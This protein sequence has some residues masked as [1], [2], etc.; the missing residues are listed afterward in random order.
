MSKVKVNTTNTF[1]EWRGKTNEI[2]SGLGDIAT[3]TQNAVIVYTNNI[4]GINKDIFIGDPATFNVTINNKATPNPIYEITII[5][6]GDHYAVDDTITILGSLVGGVDSVNDIIITVSAITAAESAIDVIT[7]VG[8]PTTDLVAE[9]NQLRTEAGLE[10]LTTTSK[11]FSGAINELDALQ[12]NV[13]L[14]TTAQTVTGAI[15]EHETDIGTVSSLTTTANN[16][17]GATNELDALQGNVNIKGTKAASLPKST[18][19]TITDAVKQIDEFQ[20]NIVLTTTAQTVTGA[21]NELDALQGNVSLTTT[22]Q[23]VT[24]AILEHETDIGSMSFNTSNSSIA[25][26]VTAGDHVNL[27]SDITSALNSLKSRSDFALDTLGGKLGTVSGTNDYDGG[28]ATIIE[29]LNALYE[30]SSLSTLDNTY[31][32]RNGGLDMTG[33]LKIDE[34]GITTTTTTDD[35]NVVTYYPMLFKVGSATANTRIHIAIDG[36]VGIGKTPSL[37]K[38]DVSGS[39]N[40]T[41]HLLDGNNIDSR[42]LRLSGVTNKLSVSNK[43]NFTSDLEYDSE[44]IDSRY[45]RTARSTEQEVST[46][47]KFTGVSKFEKELY[48]GDE[49]VY[50]STAT[51]GHTF[52]EWTQDVIGDVFTGNTVSGG[53][54]STYNDTTGKIALEIANN[55]HDHVSTNISDWDS[56]V[57]TTVGAM[58]TGNTETGIS[59]TYD[60][61]GTTNKLDFELTA[62]PIVKL[63]GDASGEVP[64]T[65]LKTETFE[66]TTAITEILTVAE[67][68]VGAA[69]AKNLK[70]S[71]GGIFDI[72]IN[73]DIDADVDI[74]GR[75]YLDQ[76]DIDTTDGDF[77]I[78]GNKKVDIDS[79]VDIDAKTTITTTTSTKNF[80]V[81]GTGIFD[82][83]VNMD[84]DADVDIN[85]KLDVDNIRIDANTISSTNTNG[86]INLSP[87]GTGATGGKVVVSG[88][89]DATT[90]TGDGG[91]LTGISDT[92]YTAGQGITLTGTVFSNNLEI[93]QPATG[94]LGLGENTLNSITSG[95]YNIALGE[96]ALTA[97]A[98][99]VCNTATGWRAMAYNI[100][101]SFNTAVGYKALEG[102]NHTDSD[103]NVAVGYLALQNSVKGYRNVAIGSRTLQYTDNLGMMFENV[104]IG[105][106]A[107]E[108]VKWGGNIGIGSGAGTYLTQA[109]RNICI[110]NNADVGTSATAGTG[111][112]CIIIGYDVQAATT[113]GNNQINIGNVWE[114]DGTDTTTITGELSVTGDVD[115]SGKLDVDN[116]RL[117][118]NTISSTNTNG[119][120][121]LSPNGTGST[122]G[123]VVVSGTLDVDGNIHAGR[124]GKNDIN[125]INYTTAL[126]G[127]EFMTFGVGINE[128]TREKARLQVDGS[129]HVDGDVIA[130]STTI[131]DERL[132]ENIQPI[133]NALSKVN[134]LNGCTFTYTADGKESAGLIAQDVEKVLPSAVCEKELPLKIDDGKEYKVLQYDQTIG[135]LVEAIKEL[136]AKVAIL[137]GK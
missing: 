96:E 38:L 126:I 130:Y 4:Q 41:S 132:K 102:S 77:K 42:Y 111:D 107:L 1:E 26:V 24:G 57:Q 94:N 86:N 105:H 33:I 101:G 120:I 55:S 15:L 75:T 85:G 121:N 103:Y 88:T 12:G 99:G 22:A 3:L 62:A 76:T 37:A 137:E 79:E 124:V 32:K 53:I 131:S 31:L 97:N 66:L 50:D 29:A 44:N 113:S 127:S 67:T 5:D 6:G 13:S 72:D 56:A 90:F 58:V 81:D 63:T 71:G 61:T 119:N 84:I 123:Q 83:D 115:I 9:V 40:A 110:G 35:E 21:I 118:L 47:N 136:T 82:I 74:K 93:N 134:Q 46:P 116:I 109:A 95:D 112:K 27:G 10:T 125:S 114:Y 17:V 36:K 69:D 117:N 25:E 51:T 87:N 30:Q 78:S 68:S 19:A 52:T 92:T 65:D 129:F 100:A 23:T 14:T 39:I 59:V 91:L 16:I 54:S 18:F 20:G 89:L 48:I 135:L 98:T 80:K 64:L 11:I 106:H 122:G 2:G 7:V 49:Q 45:L 8:T 60:T 73:M 28:E 133:E 34:L 128:S 43:V 108:N 104:A 70:V